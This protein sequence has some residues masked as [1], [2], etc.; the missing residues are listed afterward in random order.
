[1]TY[2]KIA[3]LDDVI[4]SLCRSVMCM[5]KHSIDATFDTQV[6]MPSLSVFSNWP[7]RKTPFSYVSAFDLSPQSRYLAI[8]ND[9]GK[10][11][12]YR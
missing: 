11:L 1:M 12:L 8:G 10:V 7:T 5:Y 4:K 9:K 2:Y 6:H 3:H